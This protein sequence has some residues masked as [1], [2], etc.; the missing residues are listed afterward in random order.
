MVKAASPRMLLAT[1]PLQELVLVQTVEG[2]KEIF[3]EHVVKVAIVA[4]ELHQTM[5]IPDR[6]KM[7]RIA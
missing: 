7:D 6:H 3:T 4:R 5:L 1:A 2:H